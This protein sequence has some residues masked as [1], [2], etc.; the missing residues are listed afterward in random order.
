MHVLA[1]LDGIAQLLE[2][3]DAGAVVAAI[4]HRDRFFHAL[5]DRRVGRDGA[6][7]GAGGH[8]ARARVDTG[9]AAFVT[10]E[11]V[12]HG[13]DHDDD[14]EDAGEERHEERSLAEQAL[15]AAGLGGAGAAAVLLRLRG[16][17]ERGE[18]GRGR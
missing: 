10:A 2:A 4:D 18:I 13:R 7:V 17:R 3:L 5:V 1:A 15:D 12:H 11:H 14:A 6:A 16:L 9:G 8:E